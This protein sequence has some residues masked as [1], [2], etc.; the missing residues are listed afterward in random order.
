ASPRFRG[1]FASADERFPFTDFVLSEGS[2]KLEPT[3]PLGSAGARAI[4]KAWH[5]YIVANGDKAWA[6]DRDISTAA[7]PPHVQPQPIKPGESGPAGLVSHVGIGGP[8]IEIV[9]SAAS[10]APPR[11]EQVVPGFVLS[12]EAPQ[13]QQQGTR[14]AVTRRQGN[15]LRV[16]L[17]RPF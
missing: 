10:P 4:E 13:P 3:T 17:A 15:R 6:L 8:V 2:A 1:D 7:P 12:R 14:Q 11:I 9:P 5:T 16:W